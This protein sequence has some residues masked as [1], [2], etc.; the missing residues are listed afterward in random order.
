VEK[1]GT[2]GKNVNVG[3]YSSQQHKYRERQTSAAVLV[4]SPDV[5]K[6]TRQTSAGLVPLLS[7]PPPPR[8]SE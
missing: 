3:K 8:E 4:L 6:H 7:P 2:L 5:L 1:G